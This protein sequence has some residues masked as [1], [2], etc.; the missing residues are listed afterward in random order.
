MFI[1][2]LLVGVILTVVALLWEKR[3]AKAKSKKKTSKK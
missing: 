1:W 3:E 2:E